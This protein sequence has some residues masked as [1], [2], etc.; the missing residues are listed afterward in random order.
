[1]AVGHAHAFR[2]IPGGEEEGHATQCHLLRDVFSNPFRSSVVI[3][4]AWQTSDVLRL[5]QVIYDSR[6]FS[7]MPFLSDALEEAGCDNA[8]ILT[9]CLVPAPTFAVAGWSI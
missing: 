3:D 6:D 7:S 1:L 2:G 4:E 8:E 9:H 5:A